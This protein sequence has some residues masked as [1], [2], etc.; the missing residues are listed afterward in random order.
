MTNRL[1]IILIGYGKMG[2]AI[3]DIIVSEGKH[4]VVLKISEDNLEDFTV[5]NLAQADVA[6]DFTQPDAAYDHVM[7]C[8]EA[9]LPIV[10]GTT[11]WDEG[12]QKAKT[13]ALSH[14]QT[15]F[16]SPNFSIGVNLFFKLNRQLAKLMSPYSEYQ[17]TMSEIH[18]TE[19]KDAPSGTAVKL[20]QDLITDL[21]LQYNNWKLNNSNHQSTIPIQAIREHGVPGTH[22]VRYSSEID[23]IQITHEAKSR[24]GFAIGAVRAAEFLAGKKGVYSMEDLIG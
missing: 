13:Y 10:V 20:A 17:L 5:E 15:L 11:A 19:K 14:N 1:K 7:K 12:F 8:F 23:Y 2:K 24:K 9:N 3:E 22:H 16:A 4:D 21:P 6:I 18:H